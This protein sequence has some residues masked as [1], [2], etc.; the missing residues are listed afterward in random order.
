MI[1]A[2]EVTEGVTTVIAVSGF[3]DFGGFDVS[4]CWGSGKGSGGKQILWVERKG[5]LG[6]QG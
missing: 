6:G 3:G 1:L 4:G 5:I 2:S